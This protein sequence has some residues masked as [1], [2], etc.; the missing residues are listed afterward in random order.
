MAEGGRGVT[1]L[2]GLLGGVVAGITGDPNAVL[3]GIAIGLCMD[4]LAA[5]GVKW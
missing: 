3:A 1:I 4:C 2:L 5:L